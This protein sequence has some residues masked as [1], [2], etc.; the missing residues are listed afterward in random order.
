MPVTNSTLPKRRRFQPPITSYF[1]TSTEPRSYDV[2]HHHYAAATF[3]ATPVVPDRVQ[4]SLLSVGMRVRKSVADGYK[5]QMSMQ[6]QKIAP[7]VTMAETRTAQSYTTNNNYTELTPYSNFPRS[8]VVQ[9]DDG[10]AYSLPGS[11]EST[12]SAASMPKLING[13]KRRFNRDDIFADEFPYLEDDDVDSW[14]DP[15][16]RTILSPMGQQGRRII[17]LSR[18]PGFTTQNMEVD[19]DFEEAS[20]LRRR[21]EVDLDYDMDCA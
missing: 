21:E 11:Q 6:E 8:H 10:D 2:S 3:S 15:H 18:K 20:F 13:Q 17:P 7:P 19:G 14:Q 16:S 1:S 5:T 4:S 12:T 9:T